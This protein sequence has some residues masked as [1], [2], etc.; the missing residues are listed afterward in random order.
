MTPTENGGRDRPVS[1]EIRLADG[2]SLRVS[3][4]YREVFE[5]VF[6]A[7]WEK[8]CEFKQHGVD[9]EHPITI[10]PAYIVYLRPR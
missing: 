8:P 9:G 10:N 2:E 5:R 4:D 7:G 3:E 1:T 6:A